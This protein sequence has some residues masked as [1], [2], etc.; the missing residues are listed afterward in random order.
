M[1]HPFSK[2]AISLEGIWAMQQQL[3]VLSV[4]KRLRFWIV[5]TCGDPMDLSDLDHLR[6]QRPALLLFD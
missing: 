5:L 3:L 4:A 1:A 6:R 2:L